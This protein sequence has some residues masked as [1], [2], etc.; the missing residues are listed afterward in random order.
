M[1]FYKFGFNVDNLPLNYYKDKPFYFMK[2]DALDRFGTKLE[3]RYS[4]IEIKRIMT[5]GGLK[6]I[7]ISDNPPYYCAIGFKS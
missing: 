7:K 2:T 6:N 5:S 3:K 1:I 4:K